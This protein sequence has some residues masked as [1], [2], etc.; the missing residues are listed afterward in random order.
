MSTLTKAEVTSWAGVSDAVLLRAAPFHAELNKVVRASGERVEGSIVFE[1]NVSLDVSSKPHSRGS[2][3]R[4]MY[5]GLARRSSRMLE[6]GFNAG[7]SA[8][9]ALIAVGEQHSNPA[10][11]PH[12]PSL[13]SGALSR[14]ASSHPLEHMLEAFGQ[15]GIHRMENKKAAAILATMRNVPPPPKAS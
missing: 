11:W 8:T 13:S 2:Q 14:V 7:H 4:D 12:H 6:I 15:R 3:K 10:S 5:V 9:L 1:H